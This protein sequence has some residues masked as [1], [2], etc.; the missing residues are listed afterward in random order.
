[1][2]RLKYFDRLLKKRKVSIWCGVFMIMWHPQERKNRNKTIKKA[3]NHF[4]FFEFYFL[5]FSFAIRKETIGKK[6]RTIAIISLIFDL[7]NYDI[8]NDWFI[9][10]RFLSI[11]F[12]RTTKHLWRHF[13]LRSGSTKSVLMVDSVATSNAPSHLDAL[14]SHVSFQGER[15]GRINVRSYVRSAR[16]IHMQIPPE[17]KHLS[18]PL[19]RGNLDWSSS[20]QRQGR[21]ARPFDTPFVIYMR[22]WRI[23]MSYTRREDDPSRWVFTRDRPW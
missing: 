4:H 18:S 3:T 12:I 7:Y 11:L 9:F 8:G 5:S 23:R 10:C 19:L 15:I 13:P 22:F 2:W 16:F 1:M 21:A 17:N 6:S 14:H 20:L